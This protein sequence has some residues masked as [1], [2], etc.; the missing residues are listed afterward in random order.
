M[1]KRDIGKKSKS[2]RK[3]INRR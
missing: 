2:W 1:R 3:T